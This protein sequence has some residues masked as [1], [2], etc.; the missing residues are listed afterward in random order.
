MELLQFYSGVITV[1]SKLVYGFPYSPNTERS[2][3]DLE[4]NLEESLP[5]SWCVALANRAG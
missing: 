3:L 1:G 2:V 4:R 5:P